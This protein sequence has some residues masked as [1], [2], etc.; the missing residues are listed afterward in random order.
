[1]VTN[2]ELH[3]DEVD[4]RRL[5]GMLAQWPGAAGIVSVLSGAGSVGFRGCHRLKLTGAQAAWLYANLYEYRQNASTRADTTTNRLVE[6]TVRR[7]LTQLEAA[8][9]PRGRPTPA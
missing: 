6:R 5:T 3:L 8:I 4:R 7:V 9:A 2:I 1:M